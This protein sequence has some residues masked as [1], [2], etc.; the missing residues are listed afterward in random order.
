MKKI[1]NVDLAGFQLVKGYYLVI[2]HSL[3][4][5]FPALIDKTNEIVVVLDVELLEKVWFFLPNRR[6]KIEEI[7]LLTKIN[8]NFGF[9]VNNIDKIEK[10]ELHILTKKEFNLLI[11]EKR[12]FKWPSGILCL[13][14]GKYSFPQ[15]GVI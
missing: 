1:M 12:P 7:L 11:K 2:D 9:N 5:V 4:G 8:E 14:E 6:T 15:L 13:D 10:S 3:M